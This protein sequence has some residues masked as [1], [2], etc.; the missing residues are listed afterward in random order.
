MSLANIQ[1]IHEAHD[2]HA[3]SRAVACFRDRAGNR[4][5]RASVPL[6][7]LTAGMKMAAQCRALVVTLLL[8]LMAGLPAPA[9][10][11]SA[12]ED[13]TGQT[14][15]EDVIARAGELFTPQATS[16]LG[17]SDSVW[18]LRI[19]LANE[20][21]VP[22][23][24]A[25]AFEYPLMSRVDAYIRTGGGI[26]LQ[27]NG[28]DI[29][30]S[31]RGFTHEN[32]VFAVD[33][34]AGEAATAFVRIDNRYATHLD[35]EVLELP[36]LMQ[37]LGQ[38]DSTATF[39]LTAMGVLISYNLFV[40]I[41]TRDRVY[42]YYLLYLSG[43]LLATVATFNRT[44]P[45]EFLNTHVIHLV[46]IGGDFLYVAAFLF[47]ATIFKDVATPQT[48]RVTRYMV[49]LVLAHLPVMLY[50]AAF[51]MKVYALYGTGFVI[52]AC[53]VWL[54]WHAYRQRHP[55][56]KFIAVG[57]GVF[58]VSTAFYILSLAGITSVRFQHA[59]SYGAVVEGLIFSMVLA[60]RIRLDEDNLNAAQTR[61]REI[62]AQQ[63]QVIE[64]QIASLEAAK[65]EAERA[66]YAKSAFLANMSHEIRTPM[67]AIIGMSHLLRRTRL[68][69][70]QTDKL[71]SLEGAGRHLLETINAVLDLSKIEAGKLELEETPIHLDEIVDGV[72]SLVSA[73][74]NAK[75]LQLVTHVVPFSEGL[76]GD[77]TRLK[78]AMLNYLSN[79]VKYTASGSIT[80]TLEVLEKSA[81]DAVIRVEVSD[82][83]VGIA[84]ETLSRLFSAFEQADNS[85]TRKYGGTGLG[86]AITRKIATIM[87]GDAGATSEIGKGSTF[88]FTVRLRR[89][90]GEYVK[91]PAKIPPDVEAELRQAFSGAHILLADD[92]PINRMITTAFL[93]EVGLSVDEA[94]DG[95]QAVELAARHA[96]DLILMDM[97]MPNMD[98]LEATRRIRQLSGERRVPILAMTANA[99]AE[100]KAQCIEAGMDDFLSKPVVPE[101]LY[102][103]LLE[104]LRKAPRE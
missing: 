31:Q 65:L 80:L 98:G 39:F 26:E 75:G 99:F 64:A 78:Q 94:E 30:I 55:L 36:A 22:K 86:L 81:T 56:A 32:P 53:L 63:G 15:A 70:D 57:W 44:G 101:V 19:E 24:Y 17:F 14:S 28:Y 18:W 16:S 60:Y 42:G 49:W 3:D 38:L 58:L 43:A 54:T 96:Y 48:R 76:L 23:T 87:G 5:S 73:N 61:L 52:T 41:S 71:D 83:G 20:A 1:L 95:L 68:T 100:D 88:W 97:Q 85:T 45:S 104:R 9:N 69:A 79:A 77:P 72:V 11:L 47:I 34:A 6:E 82:T 103:M 40:F 59:F 46:F 67:N 84:P 25:I 10:A 66:S 29:P 33:L 2:E 89:T 50:D 90:D 7:R 13:V 92:E 8:V 93:E 37:W 91:P 35:H 27:R 12:Y 51:A 62:N 21:P 74:A 102:A 4:C